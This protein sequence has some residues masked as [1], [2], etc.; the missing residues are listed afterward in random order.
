MSDDET[1]QVMKNTGLTQ[2][3]VTV[4]VA[5]L[6]TMVSNME[7]EQ[8]E[9]RADI[10]TLMTTLNQAQGGAKVALWLAGAVGLSTGGL[11]GVIG[12]IATVMVNG[13]IT[14]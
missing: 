14:H 9:M 7:R 5:S 11:A 6:R 1:T 4:V 13:K 2:D 10:K 12:A 8:R 3:N